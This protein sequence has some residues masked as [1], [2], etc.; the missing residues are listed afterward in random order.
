MHKNGIY[1]IELIKLVSKAIKC[2]DVLIKWLKNGC[3]E[4]AV[5]FLGLADWCLGV[6]DEIIYN[7][8]LF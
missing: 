8:S 2:I 4:F 5:G 7:P 1:N 3:L 6:F